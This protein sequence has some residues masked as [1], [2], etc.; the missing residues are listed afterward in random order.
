MIRWEIKLVM[1]TKQKYDRLLRI[2]ILGPIL[3]KGPKFQKKRSKSKKKK[4]ANLK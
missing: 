2:V 4:K 3:K 1:R